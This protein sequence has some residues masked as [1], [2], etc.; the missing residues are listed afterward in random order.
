MGCT[1]VVKFVSLSLNKNITL[2]KNF[3]YAET[4]LVNCGVTSGPKS[5]LT[6]AM[7]FTIPVRISLST[8]SVCSYGRERGRGWG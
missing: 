2:L 1:K 4:N 6:T 8:T 7:G 5:Q 3:K